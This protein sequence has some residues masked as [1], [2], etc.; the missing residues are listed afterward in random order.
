MNPL[1][2]CILFIGYSQNGK[3]DILV[4]FFLLAEYG[5]TPAVLCANAHLTPGVGLALIHMCK[6]A[7]F[8]ITALTL[9]AT[10]LVQ[11]LFPTKNPLN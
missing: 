3:T 11:S 2:F 10:T 6:H 5:D 9:H 4:R 7:H 1:G 8:T